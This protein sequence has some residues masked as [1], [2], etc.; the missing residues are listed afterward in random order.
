MGLKLDKGGR[1]CVDPKT[2]QTNRE[3]VF[4]GG[5]LVTGPYTVVDAIAAGQRAAASIDRYLQGA[6]SAKLPVSRRRRGIH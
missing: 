3:G 1:L 4:G 5:D 6:E 2:L